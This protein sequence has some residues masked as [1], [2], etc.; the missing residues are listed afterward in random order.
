[1]TERALDIQ[2]TDLARDLIA[3]IKATAERD[4]VAAIAACDGALS[5]LAPSWPEVAPLYGT[6]RSEAEWWADMAT[7]TMRAEMLSACLKYI[8]TA[9]IN[10][11]KARKQAMVA[12]WNTMDEQDRLAFLQFV[13][14]G[15]GAR[16]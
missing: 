1:M 4:S 6:A 14:P 11:G 7:D 3:T 8:A 5:I 13:D 12:I 2:R 16:V 15:P 9:P 10:T